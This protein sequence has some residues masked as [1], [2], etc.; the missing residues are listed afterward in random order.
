MIDLPEHLAPLLSGHPYLDVLGSEDPWPIPDGWLEDVQQK[1]REL[2]E[3]P[4]AQT[5]ITIGDYRANTPFTVPLMWNLATYLPAAVPVWS[6]TEV[7]L[8]D[9]LV[10]PWFT[11]P[12]SDSGR[13]ITYYGNTDYKWYLYLVWRLLER[14]PA[15]RLAA[16]ELTQRGIAAFADVPHYRER[17]AT[18]TALFQRVLDEP[19][20]RRVHETGTWDAILDVW[21]GLATDDEVETVPEVRGWGSQLAWS[22]AGLDA[23]HSHLS[24]VVSRGQSADAVIASMALYNNVDELPAALAS[25]AGQQRFV[26]ISEELDAQRAGF[27]PADWLGDNRGWLARAMVGGEID[28][29]RTVDGDGHPGLLAVRGT[30][31][32]RGRDHVPR[33]QRPRGRREE[34]LPGTDQGREPDGQAAGGAGSPAAGGVGRCRRRPAWRAARPAR[35]R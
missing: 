16:I 2:A 33:S 17:G 30:A 3:D 1:I 6:G 32:L 27:D 10:A 5:D 28:A 26:R 18:L 8:G 9:A 4:R 19:D 25:A 20:L 21:L 23:V 22:L 34:H 24:A 35:R 14:D 13:Q 12:Y 15:S 31:R 29:V 11:T 7:Q